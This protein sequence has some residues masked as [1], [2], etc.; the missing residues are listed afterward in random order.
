MSFIVNPYV[1]SSPL[2]ADADGNAFLIATGIT[3]PTIVSAICTLVTSLKSQGIWSKLD[4]I[5]PFVGGTATTH[6]YNLKNPANTNAAFR[7]SFVGGWTHSA[8]G[9]LPNATNAYAD[10]YYNNTN[11]NQNSHHMSYYSR[12]NS[13]ATEVEMG[14]F[15]VVNGSL[16]EIRTSGISYYRINNNTSFIS[17]SDAN[18]LGHYIA[19][20]T[21]S[22]SINAFKNGNQVASGSIASVTPVSLNIFIG[23]FNSGGTPQ[24]YTSKQCAFSTIGSGLTNTDASNLYSTIQTFQ[25]TLGRQ[26]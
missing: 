21:A 16:I 1:Y 5:Y 12:T 11:I 25:T 3:N 18:S 15:S 6:M 20:R 9:A 7:L 24:F 14:T 8:N 17:H 2:C 19:N 22:N 26:V 10:T 23:A 13:N 4:A